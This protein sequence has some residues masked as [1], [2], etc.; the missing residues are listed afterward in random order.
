MEDMFL[1][2]MRGRFKSHQLNIRTVIN[3]NIAQ[4]SNFD[5][6]TYTKKQM[7]LRLA[8]EIVTSTKYITEIVNEF[9]P[10]V[11]GKTI[12]MST[13]CMSE[14]DFKQVITDAYNAGLESAWTKEK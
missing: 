11:M 14:S 6:E 10:Y 7:A 8:D 3:E 2:Q 4:L 12:T 9:D 5:V 1:R 13:Y